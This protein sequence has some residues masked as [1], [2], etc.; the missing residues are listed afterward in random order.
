MSFIAS[1]VAYQAT[2]GIFGI[3]WE[4]YYS[5]LLIWLFKY[6]CIRFLFLALP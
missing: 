6:T 4:E 2:G 3:M 1:S 5:L